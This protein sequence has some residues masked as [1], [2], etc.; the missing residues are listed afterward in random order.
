MGQCE[1]TCFTWPHLTLSSSEGQKHEEGLASRQPFHS[2]PDSRSHHHHTVAAKE[3][4][5]AAER[6]GYQNKGEAG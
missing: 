5:G 2:W 3:G 1:P 6:S 4:W